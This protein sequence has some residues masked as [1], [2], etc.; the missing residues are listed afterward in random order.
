[1]F[2]PAAPWNQPIDEAPL[3]SDSDAIIS[4]LGASHDTGTRF[5]I[6]FSIEVLTASESTPKEAFIPS[7]DFYEPDCD[8]APVPIVEGG[9]IEGEDEYACESDGDCH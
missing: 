7:G 1:M 5:Q 4:Y 6:D 8:P 9:A 2:P 3:A